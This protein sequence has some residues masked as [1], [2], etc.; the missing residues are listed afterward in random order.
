[1]TVLSYF[2]P[3]ISGEIEKDARWI[4]NISADDIS[5]HP[6]FAAWSI[7]VDNYIDALICLLV[8][9]RVSNSEIQ[10]FVNIK[11]KHKPFG[12]ETYKSLDEVKEIYDDFRELIGRKPLYR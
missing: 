12:D 3:Q 7:N 10:K 9:K 1:M 6:L 11:E 8:F 4:M 2:T 5:T